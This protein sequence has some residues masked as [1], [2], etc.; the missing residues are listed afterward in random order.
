MTRGL[1]A[2]LTQVNVLILEVDHPL[3][4]LGILEPPECSG[5]LGSVGTAGSTAATSLCNKL[6]NCSKDP[7]VHLE[8]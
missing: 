8:E 3:S 6:E 5:T 4:D 2:T 1:S 7:A